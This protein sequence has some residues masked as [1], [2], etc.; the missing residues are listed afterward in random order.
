[1]PAKGWHTHQKPPSAETGGGFILRAVIFANGQL[2]HIEG[3]RAVIGSDDVLI[4][5]DGGARLCR[6][7]RLTPQVIIGDMDSIDSEDLA[8]FEQQ[9][10]DI[11]RH[12]P[13]KDQTDLE[14]ALLHAL[15]LGADQVTIL[16]GLGR[17]WDQTI[18]NLLLPTYQ[19]LSGL[20]ISYWDAGQWLHIIRDELVIEAEIGTTVSLIPLGG[21]V[22]GIDTQGLHWPLNDETLIVGATR[23]VSNS[24]SE[25]RAKLTI[26][27]GVLLC[28]V[29]SQDKN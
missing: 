12:N 15:E 23:G 3:A 11:I 28:V 16:G 27:D 1:M 4:A 20:Q 17:R 21:D 26:Q 22:T 5:A 2:N 7:L 19:K 25:P 18:A 10:A 13:D 29:G 14:L 9:G 6:V 8:A 24:M